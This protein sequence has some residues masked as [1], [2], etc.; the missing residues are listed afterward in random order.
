MFATSNSFVFAIIPCWNESSVLR[1]TVS[2]LLALGLQVV[3][4][5]DGSD[6]PMRL[7]CDGLPVHLL[8]HS[9]NLGQGA[10]LQTGMD[11]ALAQGAAYLIHFDADGQHDPGAIAEMLAILRQGDVDVLLGSRFLNQ[12]HARAVPWSKRLLLR[13]GIVVSWLFS[14]LWL[15]DTHNGLRGLTRRAAE[16]IRLTENGFSHATEI[17]EEI[18]RARLRYREIPTLVRYTE[19]SRSKGQSMGNSVNVFVDLLLHK[20]LR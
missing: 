9:V 18:R 6:T 2:E 16:Q 15:T 11:Y 14:G 7:H 5:D 13:G 1:Q 17:L 4:V 12:T 20:L 3:V 19:Y 8:R 10:A